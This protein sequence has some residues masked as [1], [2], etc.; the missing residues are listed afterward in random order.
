MNSVSEFVAVVFAVL[1]VVGHEGVQQVAPAAYAHPQEGSHAVEPDAVRR[2][3]AIMKK[4]PHPNIVSM[5]ARRKKYRDP[6]VWM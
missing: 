4:L 5:I 6:R 1:Y 3:I 2:E